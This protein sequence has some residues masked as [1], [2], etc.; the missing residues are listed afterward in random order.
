MILVS[1]LVVLK[2]R[3]VVRIRG[4]VNILFINWILDALINYDCYPRVFQNTIKM[5]AVLNRILIK[6]DLILWNI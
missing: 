3:K 1:G 4:L 5:V 2:R 6:V